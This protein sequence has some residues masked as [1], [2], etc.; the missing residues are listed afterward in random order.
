MS[1]AVP[2]TVDEPTL[3]LLTVEEAARRLSLGR[4][5]CFALVR[6]GELESVT[7]G[8]LRRIPADAIPAFANSLRTVRRA[9]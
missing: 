3:V 8:R 4:T 6:S 2:P 7:V 9:A 1:T 5:T